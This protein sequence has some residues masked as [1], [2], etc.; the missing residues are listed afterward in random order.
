M[1]VPVPQPAVTVEQPESRLL[2]PVLTLGVTVAILSARALAVFIPVMAVDLD[3][4]VSAMGQVPA[5]MLLLAGLLALVAGPLA[6]RYGFRRMLVVG[7]LSVFV[8][9]VAT[10]FSPSFPVLL[11]VTLVGAVARAAV[12]PTAQAVV[13]TAFADEDAR[14]RGIGW[15]TTG[16]STAG[17]VGIPVMTSV[18]GLTS[19]RVS[20]FIMGAMALVAAVLLRQTLADD[21]RRAAGALGIRDLGDS[22]EPIRRHRPTALMMMATLFAD[23]GLWG[24]MTY[25][26]ALLVQRHGLGI[27]AVGWAFLAISIL[28]LGGNI[29]AQGQVGKS[30]RSLLI[31]CRLGSALGL[32]L[33]FALPLSWP[34]CL[35]IVLLASPTFSMGDVATTLVL[36]ACSPAGRATTLTLRSAAVCIGTALGG[37]LGGVALAVGGYEAVGAL[38]LVVLML[39]TAVVWWSGAGREA[40]PT[41]AP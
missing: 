35:G 38:S 23:T 27:D 29:V 15:V 9:A 8:S 19:W 18:A 40:T 36:T 5:L 16:L 20:F 31:V 11:V 28:T 32:G 39:S 17:L 13:V 4:S 34:V 37:V 2:V 14:R 7:L 21:T 3:T 26:S 41:A 10:G 30:P 1:S 22:Y 25:F 33:A 6:D 12:L 24:A